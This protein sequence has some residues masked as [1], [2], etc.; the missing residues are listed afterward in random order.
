M[1]SAAPDAVSLSPPTETAT[2]NTA[3]TS[4]TLRLA[5][6]A[7]DVMSDQEFNREMR[8]QAAVQI[9]DTLLKKG[10]ISEEEYHQIKTKLLEKYRPTLSTLLAGKPLI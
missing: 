1:I 7:V 9:A 5:S 2:E 10:A 3:P 8:Y 4:V 6:K